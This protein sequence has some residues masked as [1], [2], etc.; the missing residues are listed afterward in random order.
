MSSQI[1]Q[2]ISIETVIIF[3]SCFLADFLPKG[4]KNIETDCCASVNRCVKS[5][6][7]GIFQI[8]VFSM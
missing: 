3:L 8:S 1:A 6:T 7:F 4:T 5:G 2:P